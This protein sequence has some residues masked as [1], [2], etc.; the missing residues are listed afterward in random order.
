[1]C[2]FSTVYAACHHTAYVG[3]TCTGHIVGKGL[4]VISSGK[5]LTGDNIGFFCC[6]LNSILAELC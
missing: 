1:M 4:P 6:L 5:N 3:N 2:S